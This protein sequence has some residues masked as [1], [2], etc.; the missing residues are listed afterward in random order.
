VKNLINGKRYIG[1]SENLKRRFSEYFNTNYLI[2]NNYM[3]IYR[4]LLKYDYYNFTI[5]ILEYC[6]SDKC[7]ARE[8]YYLKKLNPEY[9]T[10]KE[11]AAPMSG[12]THSEETR[13]KISDTSK[14]INHSGRFKKGQVRPEGAGSPSQAI[15]VIDKKNNKT[16]TYDSINEAAIALDIKRSRI[17]MY[18]KNNQVSPYKG[19]YIFKKI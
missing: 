18:F 2:K 7:L 9:N 15:E 8:D 1:F 5:E 13:K 17:S 3:K 12:L 14:K 11:A 19:Q 4:A 16:T 6:E 10:A